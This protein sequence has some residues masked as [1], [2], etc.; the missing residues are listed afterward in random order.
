VARLGNPTNDAGLMTDTFKA[1]GFDSVDLKAASA[2]LEELAAGLDP[3]EELAKVGAEEPERTSLSKVG[4]DWLESRIDLAEQSRRVYTTYLD[5]LETSALGRSDRA[6][7]LA[8]VVH[9]HG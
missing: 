1:A 7:H 3:R 4:R 8:P 2:L 9:A 5:S 6:A